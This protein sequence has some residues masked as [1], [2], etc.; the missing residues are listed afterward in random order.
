MK[1]SRFN[2]LRRHAVRH[3]PWIG[4]LGPTIVILG[5]VIAAANFT[6]PGDVPYSV[7]RNTISQL[8]NAHHSPLATWFNLALVSGGLF[9]TL[10]ILGVGVAVHRPVTYGIAGIGIIS[11][12]GMSGVGLFPTGGPG[13]MYHF[14]VAGGAFLA[15]FL[16]S[17]SFTAYAA[18]H[19]NPPLHRQLALVSLLGCSSVLAFLGVAVAERQRWVPRHWTRLD[20]PFSADEVRLIPLLEWIVL[21]CIL[22]WAVA[23]ALSLALRRNQL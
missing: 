19:R 2:R 4:G 23:T 6:G 22:L 12:L 17:V 20:L 16:L 1:E 5:S 10:F 14:P 3:T 8:G 9:L 21:G 11:S 7:F 18:F 13:A 15:F